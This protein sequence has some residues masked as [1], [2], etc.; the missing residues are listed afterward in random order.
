[1]KKII[2]IENLN[3]KPHFRVSWIINNICTNKCSYCPSDLH[4]GTNHNYEWANAKRFLNLLLE[5]YPKIHFCIGG[6]EPTVSPFLEEMVDIINSN[7]NNLVSITSNLARTPRYWNNLAPKLSYLCT[8]YHAEYPQDD[9]YEKVSLSS[10]Y[11]LV[12]ARVM[13]HPNKWNQCIGIFDQLKTLQNV[14]IEPVRI[15]DK[16]GADSTSHVYSE[17]QFAWFND[18]KSVINVVAKTDLDCTKD[19]TDCEDRSFYTFDDGSID[20][21]PKAVEYINDNMTNFN[22]F[23]CETSL[24]QIVIDWKGDVLLGNCAINGPIGNIN[25][26]EAIRWPT[27][28]VICRLSSCDCSLDVNMPKYLPSTPAEEEPNHH[29]RFLSNGYRFEIRP[30]NNIDCTPCCK[31]NDI[32]VSLDDPKEFFEVFRDRIRHEDPKDIAECEQCNYADDHRL[33][34][35]IR[36]SSFEAIPS[37][38]VNGDPSFLEL[39]FDRTCNGGCIMCGPEYS[40]FWQHELRKDNQLYITNDKRDYLSEILEK[41]DIQKVRRI[42]FLGGEPLLAEHDNRLLPIIDRPEL[43]DI[44]YATNGSIYPTDEKIEMWSKFN[45]INMSFSIDGIG[46]KFNYIRYPLK[47]DVVET[48]VSKL[49][50]L[51]LGNKYLHI[52]MNY[53]VNIFNLFYYD[54]IHEWFYKTGPFRKIGPHDDCSTFDIK[55]RHLNYNPAGGILSPR[56]VTPKLYNM[57]LEKYGPNHFVTTTVSNTN[58]EPSGILKYMEDIDRRRN[59]NWRK[60]FPEIADCFT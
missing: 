28:P 1:M 33:P 25:Y 19:W 47:W 12:T 20:A 55:A 56:S 34:N 54:E 14:L 45:N 16:K 44:Y 30:D 31:W 58:L 36:S 42:N 18:N 23:V 29:C 39:Q 11:T 53:T 32:G 7:K 37:D 48:N 59:L 9:F 4:S 35:T 13:M 46:D 5:R 38:V 52:S 6:G 27:A 21:D 50:G 43:V 60:I 26:P 17:E 2:K 22:G 41:I 40:S 57:L 8:S 10:K 15:Y 51:E 3:P 24:N 49:C